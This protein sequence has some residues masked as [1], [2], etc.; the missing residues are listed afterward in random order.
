MTLFPTLIGSGVLRV[1]GL[2]AQ[3]DAAAPS[4]GGGSAPSGGGAS[5]GGGWIQLVIFGGI[6][7]MFYLLVLRPQQ[8]RASTH[9]S[10]LDS[11][12]VG[13]RVVTASGLYGKITAIEGN[14]V[15]LEVA[16]RVNIRML[17]A[18]IAGLESNAA[19]AVASL[20]QR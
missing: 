4:G 16:D 18:Q 9:K 12:A 2:L 7:L 11:L 1:A 13:Q 14:D 20:T 15:K 8:K 5:Q 19:E 17:K 10:F 3:A 6:F